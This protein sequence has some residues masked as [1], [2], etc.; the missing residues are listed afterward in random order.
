MRERRN[1]TLAAH[2]GNRER[3]AEL[4]SERARSFP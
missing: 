3:C 1:L 2:L 4:K